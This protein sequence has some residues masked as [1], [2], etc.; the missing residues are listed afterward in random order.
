M[1]NDGHTDFPLLKNFVSGVNRTTRMGKMASAFR[2]RVR[3]LPD[4]VARELTGIYRSFR[5]T[6]HKTIEIYT[7]ALPF[8]PPLVDDHRESTY[9]K[10]LALA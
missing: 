6:G 5:K 2:T 7:D 9:L 8:L 3:P 10:L 1:D 4:H